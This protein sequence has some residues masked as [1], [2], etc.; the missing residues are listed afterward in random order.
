MT[1]DHGYCWKPDT[2]NAVG[3]DGNSMDWAAELGKP[4]LKQHSRQGATSEDAASK[5]AT[6]PGRRREAGRK[7][8]RKDAAGGCWSTTGG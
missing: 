8:D 3:S 7:A 1:G 5:K 2:K 4:K 6:R